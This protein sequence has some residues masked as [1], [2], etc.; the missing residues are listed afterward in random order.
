MQTIGI[1]ILTFNAASTIENLIKKLLHYKDH[2]IVIDSSSK[3]NTIEI[4]T[5]YNINHV[6]IPSSEF[7]H[8]KTREMARKLLNTD[9]VIYMTQDVIP[10]DENLIP[11]L[12]EPI[13]KGEAHFSYA[14][15]LPRP[16]AGFF[17]AFPRYYNYPHKSHIR[18]LD[19]IDKYG[20]F[21]FFNS[22]S[23]SAY[24]NKALDD[25]GGFVYT[26]VSED[27]IA[28][29]KLLQKNYKIAYVAE[30]LVY[31]S[32][33]YTL[34]EEFQRYFDIGYVHAENKWINKLVGKAEKRGFDYLFVMLKELFPRK[35]HLLPYA[36]INNFIKYIGYK[37][38]YFL[39]GKTPKINKI[40]SG[41]KYFWDN[42]K[43]N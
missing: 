17:E 27:Y 32:H 43:Q 14:R 38:G 2:I 28:T 24:L 7:N 9:I 4:L 22:D 13:V 8:G 30:A 16:G 20:V 6:I 39:Y 3:D 35:V 31:H 25:I 36:I 12:I 5:K 37:M 10:V 11:K 29:A 18:A 23:C 19:D 40:F 21:T 1:I 33:N 34:I 26:L 41:Q 42:I 15:Q